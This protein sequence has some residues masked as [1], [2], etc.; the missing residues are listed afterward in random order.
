[1]HTSSFYAKINIFGVKRLFELAP[2]F[3]ISK[4]GYLMMYS[5]TRSEN[6][7]NHYNHPLMNRFSFIR[8]LGAGMPAAASLPLARPLQLR[9]QFPR[10]MAQ[11]VAALQHFSCL[12]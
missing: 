1:M 4:K 8:N 12:I 6:N 11:R 3:S 7:F 10:T 5:P 9:F 2:P